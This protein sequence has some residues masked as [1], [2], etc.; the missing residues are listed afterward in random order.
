MTK[1]LLKKIAD[2]ARSERFYT[3]A[4]IEGDIKVL[5]ENDLIDIYD[6]YD[7]GRIRWTLT[8]KGREHL[9]AAD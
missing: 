1:A 5:R 4:D 2:A 3:T 7:D 9:E 6:M 8:A